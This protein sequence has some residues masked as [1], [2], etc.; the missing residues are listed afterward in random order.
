[1]AR[2]PALVLDV[3]PWLEGQIGPELDAHAAQR[4][5]AMLTR[6]A[7]YIARVRAQAAV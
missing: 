3:L 1:M 6:Y 7:P 4:F 5:E 2:G